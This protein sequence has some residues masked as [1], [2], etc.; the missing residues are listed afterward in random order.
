M[1]FCDDCG[2]YLKETKEGVW[3]PKCGKK[4]R[5]TQRVKAKIVRKGGSNAI[6]VVD[7]PSEAQVE[8]M[9]TCPKCRN[10]KAFRWISTI[11]GEHAGVRRERTLEHFKCT[12]CYYSWSTSS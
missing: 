12:K 11:S 6:Y 7:K 3:C 10:E 2:S 4:I 8:V 9:H 1:R 5:S